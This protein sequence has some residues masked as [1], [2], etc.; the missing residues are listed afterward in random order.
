[1]D[2]FKKAYKYIV[3]GILTGI[4][5][6]VLPGQKMAGTL[7]S[8]FGARGFRFVINPV[9]TFIFVPILTMATAG[10]AVTLSLREIKRI[11]SSEC[12]NGGTE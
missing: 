8:S 2:Y 4:I 10:L 9:L 11:R 12:L 1:M 3:P 6:G 7:L 5:L